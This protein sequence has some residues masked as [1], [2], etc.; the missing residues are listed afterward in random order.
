MAPSDRE[1]ESCVIAG[2]FTLTDE[3]RRFKAMLMAY[4]RLEPFWDFQRR[5]CDIEALRSALGALSSGEQIMA[6]FFAAVWAGENVLGFDLID[7]ARTLEE[8]HLVQIQH[9]LADPLFP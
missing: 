5:E 7:A 9:W 3:Q 2:H 8:A 6:R 1:D 4:P